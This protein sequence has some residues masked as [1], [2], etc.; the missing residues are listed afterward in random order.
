MGDLWMRRVENQQG[1]ENKSETRKS[2]PERNQI[3]INIKNV[4]C[5]KW[6]GHV[7]PVT[8]VATPLFVWYYTC[9]YCL[10]SVDRAIDLSVAP[11][12]AHPCQPVI[13]QVKMTIDVK[14]KTSKQ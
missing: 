3:C 11:G 10:V 9:V 2:L 7:D 12:H 13:E 4:V 14:K 6:A 5:H 1:K 8:P